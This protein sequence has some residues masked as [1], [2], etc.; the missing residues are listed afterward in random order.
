MPRTH[1]ASNS[2]EFVDLAI[3]V[4]PMSLG[5]SINKGKCWE[6][7]G[8]TNGASLSS[9]S[10]E[11]SSGDQELTEWNLPNHT[12]LVHTT[13]KGIIEDENQDKGKKK[14]MEK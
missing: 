1:A 10:L 12:T 6:G 14:A 9:S 13:N 11:S 7:M 3:L 4:A 8:Y 2:I 5:F